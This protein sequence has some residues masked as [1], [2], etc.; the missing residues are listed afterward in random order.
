MMQNLCHR[1]QIESTSLIKPKPNLA[2]KNDLTE[3]N[4][5]KPKTQGCKT[6]EMAGGIALKVGAGCVCGAEPCCWKDSSMLALQS[7]HLAGARKHGPPRKH[8]LHPARK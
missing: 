7:H 2:R 3:K 1:K 6:K 5:D 4:S 8:T